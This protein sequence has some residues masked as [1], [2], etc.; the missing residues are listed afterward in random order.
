MRVSG[1]DFTQFISWSLWP[2]SVLLSIS[3]P[4]L[5]YIACSDMLVWIISSNGSNPN[6]IS[7]GSSICVVKYLIKPYKSS[8]KT[9]KYC[10]ISCVCDI[11]LMSNGIMWEIL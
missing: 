4:S 5:G 11:F 7:N 3:R 2:R 6:D 1:I 9:C 8:S 10:G